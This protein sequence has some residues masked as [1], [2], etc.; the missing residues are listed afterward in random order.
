MADPSQLPSSSQ[1]NPLKPKQ[2]KFT[3]ET[4]F[5]VFFLVMMVVLSVTQY[6]YKPPVQP[7]QA[8]VKKMEVPPPSVAALPAVTPGPL[9]HSA[10]AAPA[11]ASTE[12]ATR[13]ENGVSAVEFSNRGGGTIRSWVLTK[14]KEANDK[15]LDMVNASGKGIIPPPMSY[16][17]KSVK[18][19]IDLNQALFTS[20]V[21]DN[22]LRVDFE[23][24]TG[25]LVARRSYQFKKDSYL[26]EITSEV[27]QNG[28][29]VPHYLAW[30]GGFGDSTVTKYYG[31]QRTVD[32]NNDK[33]KLETKDPK[34]AKDG[35]QMS[36]GSY[37]FAGVQD[38]YFGLAFLPKTNQ[39]E[40]LSFGDKLKLVGTDDEEY[41]AGAGV[42]GDGVNR[43]GMFAGPKDLQI[44]SAANPKLEPLIDWG[45]FGFVAKPLFY[46]M[47][48]VYNNVAH[49]WGWAIVLVTLTINL[50]LFPLRFSSM[51]S[52][53]KSAALQPEMARIKEKYKGMSI[54]D[55]KKQEENQEMM[56]MYKKHGI[57]PVG[58]CV[59][60]V[61]QLPILW[62]FYSVLSNII[63]MRGASWLW[64]HDLSRPE[65][66]AIRLLPVILLVTQFITQKM[67][68]PSPGM[69]P[70]QQKMMMVMP[71]FM[72]YIFY[73]QSSGLVLYWLTSNL[74]GILLQWVTN[75]MMPAVK[76][77]VIDV[78]PV[79]KKRK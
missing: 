20:K 78:K 4:R 49:N 50:A 14:F 34:D 69:D 28:V 37:G 67:T 18:P 17:F 77:A 25:Q 13:I 30:R 9:D 58:G 56:D 68:P 44:L 31:V 76:P 23:Y 6:F 12:A 70:S 53:K 27:T 47:T 65:T 73:Y 5:L 75:R 41:H 32:Y 39:M 40:L 61:L 16:E 29:L 35:P 1:N 57:N 10:G 52:A 60:L 59:P 43:L 48:W 66:L 2:E 42:G 33:S 11:Q 38:Q 36:S 45:F 26:S 22:G 54:T 79:S 15:P 71:L 74:M 7:P 19:A 21:S 24:S 55:P 72:G 8:P 64:V 63:A 51:K 3:M 62:A 46:A